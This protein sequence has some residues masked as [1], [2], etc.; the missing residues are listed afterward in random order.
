MLQVMT[1][2]DK[3]QQG[4]VMRVIRDQRFP[5]VYVQGLNKVCV[6]VERAW[7]SK[8]QQQQKQDQ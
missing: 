3:G 1:G 2:K 8:V 6:R 7:L 4:E 5:R